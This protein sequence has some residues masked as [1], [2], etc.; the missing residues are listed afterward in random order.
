M[1]ALIVMSSS[2]SLITQVLP[3]VPLLDISRSLF[4]TTIS[5]EL[6]K[7]SLDIFVTLYQ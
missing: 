4:C 2:M 7:A 5:G 3:I 6:L 1:A